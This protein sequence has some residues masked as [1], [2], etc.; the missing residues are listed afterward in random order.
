MKEIGGYF[1]LQLVHGMTTAHPKVVLCLKSGRACLHLLLQHE[2]P[3]HMWVPYYTC[4]ALL[5][6]FLKSNIKF[7]FYI[8]DDRLEIL[9]PIPQIGPKERLIYINY[10][11]L[12]S[13]YS[14]QLE[15]QFGDRLWLDQTHAFYYQPREP[16]AFHFNSAR[17]F[18][19]VPDG[20][21]L[22]GP[23][24]AELLPPETWPRNTDYRFEHLLLRLQGKTEE[25]YK[26]FQDNERRSGEGIARMSE[27]TEA[28]LSQI[29]FKETARKRQEN[30][31]HLHETLRTS[32]RLSSHVVDRYQDTAPFC[33]P[34]LPSQPMEK[35]YFWEKQ[36]FIPIFWREC[37]ERRD[38][39]FEWEKRIT[40]DLL[41]LPIDHRYGPAEMDY[42]I[43]VIN[44]YGK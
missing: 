30:Y 14:A 31:A 24:S 3:D 27:L 13:N 10:F 36:I 40:S 9:S 44:I 7:S 42:L 8:I 5:E 22:Y 41:P 11:G 39:G 2:R 26:I 12:K 28:I 25:G 34:F 20:A 23:D 33:Y 43:E 17:K 18:F 6:P 1:E 37:L 15:A 21:Y 4:D 35:S 19:G 29:D 32:N 16:K 38:S